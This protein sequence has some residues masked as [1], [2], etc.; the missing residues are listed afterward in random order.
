V[1]SG[2]NGHIELAS[3]KEPSMPSPDRTGDDGA[4]TAPPASTAAADDA[5]GLTGA[6]ASTSVSCSYVYGYDSDGNPTL[7]IGGQGAIRPQAAHQAPE[8][9]EQR[10]G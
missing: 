9:R 7:A 10:G 4:A 6:A 1:P 8:A 3:R 2:L 5:A